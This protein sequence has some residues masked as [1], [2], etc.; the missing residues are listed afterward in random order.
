MTEIL[1]QELKVMA[2]RRNLRSS[3]RRAEEPTIE[4]ATLREEYEVTKS[5]PCLNKIGLEL[6][7]L[8]LWEEQ[9]GEKVVLL[10]RVDA[11][12]SNASYKNLGMTYSN[13]MNKTSNRG[14]IRLNWPILREYGLQETKIIL[15]RELVRSYLVQSGGVD[16]KESER[17]D[18]FKEWAQLITSRS[19]NTLPVS[20]NLP[21]NFD[22]IGEFRKEYFWVCSR[23]G[24]ELTRYK[25]AKPQTKWH[26]F[27]H[28]V[29]CKGHDE[30]IWI[31]DSTKG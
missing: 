12:W 5:R 11:D 10:N 31:K 20:E 2:T 28:K 13:K 17:A 8:Y 4:Y 14:T 3:G 23:C 22:N 27:N 18:S 15:M 25:N 6:C 9:D 1:F 30:H 7:R 16:D 26:P 19:G 24:D 29:N 21:K